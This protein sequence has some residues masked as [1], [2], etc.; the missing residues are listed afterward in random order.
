M[1]KRGRQI[2]KKRER[3]RERVLGSF[4]L[5]PGLRLDARIGKVLVSRL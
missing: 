1:L 5:A 3:E 2:P 4:K